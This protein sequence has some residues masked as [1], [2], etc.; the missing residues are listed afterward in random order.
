MKKL[1]L[2]LTCLS[3][4]TA[5]WAQIE[6]RA[7]AGAMT[8][9]NPNPNNW[10]FSHS[11]P[12]LPFAAV[13]IST[14]LSKNWQIG[15]EASYATIKIQYQPPKSFYTSNGYSEE[16]KIVDQYGKPL[17]PILAF[18]NRK[19]TLPKGYLYCGLAV[20]T[21]I[22]FKPRESFKAKQLAQNKSIG[23]I[24][25]AQVGY[26]LNITSRVDL[27]TEIAARHLKIGKANIAYFPASLGV[28]YNL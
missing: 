25:G 28:C 20:G 22:A 12:A 10:E 8:A 6:I 26:T 1:I 13:Q 2:I 27:N 17:V 14:G 7:S 18:L 3:Y 9:T 19:I 16:Y 5:V 21:A 15:L 4:A 11:T 23:I 24:A